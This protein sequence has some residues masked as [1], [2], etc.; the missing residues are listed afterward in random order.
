MGTDALA[1]DLP[2]AAASAACAHC[3][4]PAPRGETYC[5][6]GCATVA[7]ALADGGLT[8]Y[9]ARPDRVAAAARTTDRGY[10]ELDDEAFAQRH[11]R[12]RADGAC[13]TSFYLEDLRC[14]ACVW[15]VERVPRV[16]DGVR[17]IRVDLGRGRADVVYDPARAPLSSVARAID[18]LGHPVHPYRG[19]D[20][21]A[22]RRREDR[23]LLIKIAVAGAAA[24]N[25]MLLA[26]ALYAGANGA[27][28]PFFRWASMMVAVPALSWAATPFWRGALAAVRARRLHLDLPISIGVA[29]GLAW[30]A[31]DVIAGTGEPYFDSLAMLVFLLLSARWLQARQTRRASDAAEILRALTPS[32]ALRVEGDAVRAVPID[33][34]AIGDLIEARAGDTIAVD[35]VIASGVSAVDAGLLTGEPR[36]VDVGAGDAVA[37][38]AV[39]LAAPLRIRTTAAGMGTRVGRLAARLGELGASRPRITQLVDRVSARFVA[40]VLIA[41]AV[42]VIAWWP[43]GPERAV[44]HAMALLV[45]TC[46]CALALATPLTFGI[47]IG[48]AARRGVLIKSHDALERLAGPRPTIVLDKTGTVTT[49]ALR[50]ETWHGPERAIAAAA[51]L[52]RASAHPL[53]RAIAASRPDARGIASDVREE[54]GRGI[55]GLV[56]GVRV[57]VGSPRWIA[58][59]AEIA[60]DVRAA[61]DDAAAAAATPVVVAIDGVARAVAQLVDPVRDDARASIDR[62]RAMGARLELLSG[63]D[64]RVVASVGA[65]LGLPRD[66]CRGGATPE[67]KLAR[68]QALAARG[69]TIMVGDGVNDAAALAAA[70]AGIA[71][72][73]G[74]EASIDAAD[75]FLRA[76]GL[77]PVADVVAGARASLAA[78]RR[79]LR[80]SLTYNLTMG[81]LAIAGLVHP[82]LAAALMPASSLSVLA[83]AARAR[84]FRGGAA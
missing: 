64:P 84:A 30:G 27:F 26:A 32:S 46:P 17:E 59:R 43:A 34:I 63:D 21:D 51:V 70:T 9:Y 4:L 12:A 81:T 42:T 37:A 22:R 58:A 39:N 25:V 14:G 31:H 74:A 53:A 50:V 19:V 68:V 35:G 77:A 1:L 33:A 71:V 67:D 20:R 49:G 60:P 80:V 29:A 24:G 57:A 41:A 6:A 82:L 52:E 76:P 3:G 28:A 72:H 83:L 15:L 56:G 38:G 79:S 7:R 47:A 13:E 23:A 62:L 11:V 73:G 2:A 66:A 44:A 16:V 10:A 61:I 78:V 8:A 18:R 45:V 40:V 54:L 5:C 48:R 36:P 75:V 55:A 69:P 65:A